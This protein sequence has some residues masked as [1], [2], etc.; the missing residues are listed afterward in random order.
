MLLQT[1]KRIKGSQVSKYRSE[2]G[3][4]VV[5]VYVFAEPLYGKQLQETHQ[6]RYIN[7]PHV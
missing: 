6:V 3:W 5:T 4:S 2:I 7:I 1:P